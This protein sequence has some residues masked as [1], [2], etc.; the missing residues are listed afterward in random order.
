MLIIVTLYTHYLEALVGTP[1]LY[2][3]PIL[4]GTEISPTLNHHPK[5]LTQGG[6]DPC[7][8]VFYNEH[9]NVT[10]EMETHQI[11]DQMSVHLLADRNGTS[12][13]VLCCYSA[14]ASRFSVTYIQ[15][16]SSENLDC[17]EWLFKLLLPSCQLEVVWLT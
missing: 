17:N 16:C 3:A 15:R 8:R 6:M 7:V 10:A 1:C 13:V 12:G 14:S 4:S 5:P 9:L 11:R 2:C